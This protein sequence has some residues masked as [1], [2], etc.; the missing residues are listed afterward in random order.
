M[1]LLQTSLTNTPAM[2]ERAR[3]LIRYAS[4]MAQSPL[5]KGRDQHEAV[6]AARRAAEAYEEARSAIL[7]GQSWDALK[8]LRRTGERVALSAAKAAHVHAFYGDDEVLVVV[9]DGGV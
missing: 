8:T 9:R 1:A 5:C 7:E 6:D 2:M 4:S 3:K